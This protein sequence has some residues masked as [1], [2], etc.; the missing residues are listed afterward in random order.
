MITINLS[1]SKDIAHHYRREARQKEFEPFDLQVTIPSQSV[2]AEQKRQEI[3]EK[4]YQVQTQIDNCLSIDE[5]NNIV[6]LVR[7]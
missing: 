3:R 7:G 5:L 6:S 4:Y 2:F 1:K